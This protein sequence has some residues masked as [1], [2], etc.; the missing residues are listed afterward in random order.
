MSMCSS[1]N[2]PN[3]RAN[4]VCAGQEKLVEANWPLSAQSLPT[5]DLCKS[6]ICLIFYWGI[7]CVRSHL[8]L[9]P[10]MMLLL[11]RVYTATPTKCWVLSYHLVLVKPVGLHHRCFNSWG[12]E[13]QMS[14]C[15]RWTEKLHWS[16]TKK[17]TE[18]ASFFSRNFIHT[19][20]LQTEFLCMF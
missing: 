12:S 3:I 7:C 20:N 2:G 4:I 18:V 14:E 13:L 5:V 9:I 6:I 16:H 17:L 8:V 1:I 15:C 11:P 10:S 19:R